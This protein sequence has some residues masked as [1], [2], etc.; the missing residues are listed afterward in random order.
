MP[1]WQ[2]E[3]D[4]ETQARVAAIWKLYSDVAAWPWWNL[5]I[6]R[7]DLSGLFA[8]GTV[9]TL[10]LK[11]HRAVGFRLVAVQPMQGFTAEADLLGAAGLLRCSHTL[12]VIG[13][14]RTRMTHALEI[15]GPESDAL[16]AQV[17]SSLQ[18]KMDDA[19]DAVALQA[20]SDA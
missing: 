14:D 6:D 17:G 13:M 11:D 9:G 7:V 16:G 15:L 2:Y 10:I 8:A 4:V 18:Q 1:M 19:M 5:S 12:R 3:R 20:L